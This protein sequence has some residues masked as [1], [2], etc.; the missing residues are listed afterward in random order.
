M[1]VCNK[2]SRPISRRPQDRHHNAE[3]FECVTGGEAMTKRMT[4]EERAE[5]ICDDY[6]SSPHSMR[7]V[8]AQGIKA[9]RKATLEAAAER[10]EAAKKGR[11]RQG[12]FSADMEDGFIACL[13][14]AENL[15]LRDEEE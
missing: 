13:S 1:A 14:F 2:Q 15:I 9:D 3:S 7:V 6:N 5:F 4:A 8:I 11:V 12:F 10:I